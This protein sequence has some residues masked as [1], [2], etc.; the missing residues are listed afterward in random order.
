MNLADI[1]LNETNQPQKDKYG[2]LYMKYLKE[3]N[4]EKQ[5]EM[6][7]PGAGRKGWGLLF[8]EYKV[9]VM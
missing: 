9:S 3:S 7:L 4:S 8:R 6:V 1:T 5:S 2:F